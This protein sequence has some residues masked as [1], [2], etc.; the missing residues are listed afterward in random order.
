MSNARDPLAP[1][2][3]RP[4]PGFTPPA[5]SS[6][7]LPILLQG[8]SWVVVDKPS[9]LLSVPGRAE[10]QEDCVRL[11]VAEMFP[12]REAFTVHRLD[13]ETSGCIIVA[14]SADAHR[15][16]NLQFERRRVSK[17]YTAVLAGN[18]TPDTGVVRLPL[19]KDWPRRPKQKV[20]HDAGKPA[21]THYRVLSRDTGRTRVEF[22]PITGRSHQIRV[23]AAHP[24]GLNAPV[25]G[26]GLYGDI[27]AAPR[28]LLHATSISFRDPD[29]NTMVEAVSPPPF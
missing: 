16:L 11:R 28:L 19:S 29:T 21:E 5:E 9:G 12:D 25:L 14:L 7:A 24:E 13:W 10:G 2:T 23:H 20:D 1:P 22:M 27:H 15:D 26:D 4:H 8:P 6:R 17:I 3:P 18:V